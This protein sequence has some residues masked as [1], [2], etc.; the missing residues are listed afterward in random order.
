MASAE[1]V[2]YFIELESF[3]ATA[4]HT[5][6]DTNSL[7]II[8]RHLED[9]ISIIA[10]FLV[11]MS[12]PVAQNVAERTLC[13]ILDGIYE[14]LC[15]MFEE[16][17]LQMEAHGMGTHSASRVGR[18]RYNIPAVQL[19]HMRDLGFS[20]MAISR[21]LSV[22]IRTLYNHRTHLGLVDYGSFTNISNDDLGRLIT[23]VLSQTPGS[24]ETYITGS[25]RGRGIRVQRWRVREQLRIVDPV[26]RALRGRRAIQRRIYNV[27]VPNQVWHIDT[28]HKL[29]PWGFVFHGGVDGYSRCITYLRCCTDNRAATALQLFQGAVDVFGLPHHVRSDAGSENIDIA[30]F[31]IENRGANRASFMV[32]RSVHNQRIERLW[33][34]LNRVVSAYFK[35]LFLFMENVGILDSTDPLH[36]RA[37]Y[38]VYLPRVNRS[39]D[40]FVRQWNNHSLRTMESRSPLQLWT[41]GMLQLPQ[42]VRLNQVHVQPPYYHHWDVDLMQINPMIDDGNHGIEHFLTA[43]DLLQR[44]D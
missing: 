43:C 13:I 44:N 8:S 37:L 35:D 22:N 6:N 25:L 20:W 10:T 38:H 33:G 30:R 11:L 2:Q 19:T 28:N 21:M 17:T 42:D 7:E 12:N 23:Q 40:E 26:G 15:E 16:V 9:H 32:G 29:N 39:V 34:E 18:P 5:P 1:I 4:G 27:S 3:F 36:I 14:C 31:M 24:G 41:V